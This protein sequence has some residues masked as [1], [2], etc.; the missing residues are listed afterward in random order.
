MDSDMDIEISGISVLVISYARCR[1][2]MNV[3][4]KFLR[5]INH[6]VSDRFVPSVIDGL[7]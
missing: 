7:L 4:H 6:G 1:A 5:L 3:P 2:K